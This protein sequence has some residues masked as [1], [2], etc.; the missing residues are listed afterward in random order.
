[1]VILANATGENHGYYCGVWRKRL[2]IHRRDV[3]D[4]LGGIEGVARRRRRRRN[5]M[6]ASNDDLFQSAGY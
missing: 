3:S 6:A 2:T 1:M 5:I 4:A